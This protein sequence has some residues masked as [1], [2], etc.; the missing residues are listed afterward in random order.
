MEIVLLRILGGKKATNTVGVVAKENCLNLVRVEVGCCSPTCS[1]LWVFSM[2][3]LLSMYRRMITTMEADP[4]F[5]ISNFVR[6][7]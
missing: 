7:N 5:F 2:V 4:H 6:L 1:E 3:T